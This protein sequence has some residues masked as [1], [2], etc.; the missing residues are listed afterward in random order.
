MLFSIATHTASA[1]EHGSLVSPVDAVDVHALHGTERH[2]AA[3]RLRTAPALPRQRAFGTRALLPASACTTMPRKRLLK[4]VLSDTEEEE[5]EP[6]CVQTAPVQPVR[7]R[8]RRAG[9]PDEA[10]PVADVPG[11]PVEPDCTAAVAAA[12]NLP[13]LAEP[14]PQRRTPLCTPPATPPTAA[15]TPPT[16]RSSR[17]QLGGS[18][19]KAAAA[20]GDALARLRRLRSGGRRSSPAGYD[21]EE[22]SSGEGDG[23]GGSSSTGGSTGSLE[24][25]QGRWRHAGSG[26]RRRAREEHSEEGRKRARRMERRRAQR[27]TWRLTDFVVEDDG[28]ALA[29]LRSAMQGARLSERDRHRLTCQLRLLRLLGGLPAD[30]ACLS[31]ADKSCITRAAE[32]VERELLQLSEQANNLEGWRRAD[33]PNASGLSLKQRFEQFPVVE[34]EQGGWRPGRHCAFCRHDR[35]EICMLKLSFLGQ[36]KPVD[37]LVPELRRRGLLHREDQPDVMHGVYAQDGGPSPS[38]GSEDESSSASSSEQDEEVDGEDDESS[39]SSLGSQRR[40]LRRRQRQRHRQQPVRRSRRLVARLFADDQQGQRQEQDSEEEEEEA[41]AR[42]RRRRRAACVRGEP[43]GSSEGEGL[44][45]SSDHEEQWEGGS[46]VDPA[47]SVSDGSGA[48]DVPASRPR[49]H[50]RIGVDCWA[51]AFVYGSTFRYPARLD[52]MLMWCTR[53]YLRS[54][55]EARQP[56]D[57]VGLAAAVVRRYGR[58]LWRHYASFRYTLNSFNLLQASPPA[59]AGYD[60]EEDSSG[61]GDGSG[62]SSSTGGSTSSLEQRQGRRRRAGSGSRRRAREEHSEED[63]EEGSEDGEEEGSEDDMADFVVEDDGKALAML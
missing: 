36:P 1:L 60:E 24:Q 7:R 62:S 14:S 54:T 53:D 29:M 5:D 18:A 45:G 49:L 25:R 38:D 10:D 35:G 15:G 27:M 33:G 48:W 40:G 34:A 61:E 3:C 31:E 32:G 63:S 41:P 55:P 56:G 21:E 59:H 42:S 12:A 57:V 19:T 6:G 4:V 11:S 43:S 58:Q 16:W 9:R 23:S 39:S 50:P 37:W 44:E 26:S 20:R 17:R 28:K 22:D 51:R 30:G 13:T 46:G 2:C 52:A 47:S 8:L